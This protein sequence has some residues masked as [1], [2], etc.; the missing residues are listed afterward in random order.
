[1]QNFDEIPDCRGDV[2]TRKSHI[3]VD[4]TQPNL[5]AHN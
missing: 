4:G 3:F 5:D 1:M 2:I